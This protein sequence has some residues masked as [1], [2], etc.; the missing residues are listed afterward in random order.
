MIQQ[1]QLSVINMTNLPSHDPFGHGKFAEDPRVVELIGRSLAN[2]QVLTDSR[3][4]L[5]SRLML[6]TAGAASMVGHAAG[7]V[8][9]A[10]VSVID[11]ET[12]NNFGDQV[13]EFGQS[14]RQ[15][16]SGPLQ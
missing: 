15:I 11:P 14:V 7:L 1:E 13:D 2:G 4:G 10:P 6:T 5:G 12:R 8:L 9:S 16:G 3:V